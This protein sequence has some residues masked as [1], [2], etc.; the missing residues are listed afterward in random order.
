VVRLWPGLQKLSPELP[1]PAPAQ[2]D[3]TGEAVPAEPRGSLTTSPDGKRLL[4]TSGGTALR[5]WD[6]T[7]SRPL[8]ELEGA[9]ALEAVAYSPDGRWIAGSACGPDTAPLRLW[10]AA[11][12]RLRHTLEGQRPPITA[13]AFAPDSALLA[14]G[15]SQSTDVWLWDV[16]RGE[17]AL[18][19][20]DAI[21]GCSVEALAFHPQG[22]WLAAGGVD[23]LATGG[24]DGAVAVWDAADRREVVTLDGAAT[25]L[26]FDPA[27]RRLAA[28][29]LS[30]SVRLWDVG[31][32]EGGRLRGEPAAVLFGHEEAVTSVAYSP[33][34]RLLVSGGLDHTVCL[35]DAATGDL[36]GSLRLDT[37]IKAL[38]FSPEG[39][40]LFTGNGNTSCYQ[41]EVGRMPP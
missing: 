27:G 4:S 40:Y 15:G 11:T 32:W 18:L 14:S 3:S 21:D 25:A 39:R 6:T 17:P 38:C 19:I 22:R 37:Q 10:D 34:G 16:A 12:G 30:R 13:L 31:D 36:L 2:P 9:A 41:V 20:P 33:D 29:S 8:V 5:A 23:W 28:A 24:S 35:W 7:S 1:A 26:A